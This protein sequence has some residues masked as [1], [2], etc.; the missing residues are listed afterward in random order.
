MCAGAMADYRRL[1]RGT[2]PVEVRIR[3]N[4]KSAVWSIGGAMVKTIAAQGGF[5]TLTLPP[6]AWH[7]PAT[8]A[9]L[10]GSRDDCRGR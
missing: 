2:E 1:A 8:H 3:A 4:A 5:Y 7:H 10:A 6:S 9:S